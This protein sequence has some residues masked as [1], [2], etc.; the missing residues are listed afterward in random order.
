MEKKNLQLGT[1]QWY[2]MPG[3]VNTKQDF[4]EVPTL[5][6]GVLTS[7]PTSAER[8][9]GLTLLIKMPGFCVGPLEMLVQY[10]TQ[11]FIG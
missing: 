2:R 11:I 9:P 1:L 7:K 6:S 8:E 4:L 5:E 3:G 10:K